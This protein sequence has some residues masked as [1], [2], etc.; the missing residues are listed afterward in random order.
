MQNY[1]FVR[2]IMHIFA[3]EFSIF[4]HYEDKEE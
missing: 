1:L 2:K 3:A 4:I